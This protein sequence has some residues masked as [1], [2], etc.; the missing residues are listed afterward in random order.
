MSQPSR[1]GPDEHH[2]RHGDVDRARAAAAKH[3]D[4]AQPDLA[5]RD[6]LSAQGQHKIEE[7]HQAHDQV[8]KAEREQRMKRNDHREDEPPHL[9]LPQ[10]YRQHESIE[11]SEKAEE[12][13]DLLHRGEEEAPKSLEAYAGSKMPASRTQEAYV[14]SLAHPEERRKL[15]TGDERAKKGHFPA[16][17]SPDTSK[18][19]L[20][21]QNHRNKGVA[22]PEI[23]QPG[24]KSF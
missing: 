7:Q 14:A 19:Q 8:M 13:D 21:W 16:T 18:I 9:H 20:Q 5:L 1:R 24:G 6:A 15:M 23:T 22:G 11:A 12:I 3:Q 17:A 10:V 4:D 2:L